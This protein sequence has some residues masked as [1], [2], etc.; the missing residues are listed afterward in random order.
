VTDN[1]I[2]KQGYNDLH[3]LACQVGLQKVTFECAE[4]NLLLSHSSVVCFAVFLLV[5]KWV[6]N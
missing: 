2:P 5:R 3:N 6:L 4:S 1:F